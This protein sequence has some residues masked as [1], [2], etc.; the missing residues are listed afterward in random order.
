[1]PTATTASTAVVPPKPSTP[2]AATVPK[3]GATTTPQPA[4]PGLPA[5]SA[6]QIATTATA[7]ASTAAATG[8]ISQ[9]AGVQISQNT[10]ANTH[11]INIKSAAIA[12]S[13]RIASL[14]SAML[15]DLNNIQAGVN[16]ISSLL[17][18]GNLK[19]QADF[20]MPGG[21]PG[22]GNGGPAIFG[23]SASKFGLEMTS[24]Y[25]PG[26]KGYHGLNR[27]RDYSNGSGPT[28]QMMGF[29]QYLYSMF[30]SNLKELIYTPLGFSVK[31][32]RKVAPYAQAQHYD[33]VHVA[34][35][36]GPENPVGFGSLGAAQAW[37]N[38]MVPGSVKVASIT[39]NSSEGFGGGSTFNNTITIQ[40]QPGQDPEQ[41]AAIVVAK[42]GEWVSDAR[43]SSIF[44]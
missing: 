10:Q 16:R 42:M 26:D 21:P 31:D 18:S 30:G 6:P 13:N 32:G 11:L 34:W 19:V 2:A 5:T 37:E 20:N 29:A 28:P 39:G 23:S 43:S 22:G 12:I 1:V 25:R 41:L 3:P 38:S 40:Q 35:A 36:Y 8:Q 9:K 7:T 33:H 27:A 44:V 24:G 17:A 4:A 14:Q 15:L